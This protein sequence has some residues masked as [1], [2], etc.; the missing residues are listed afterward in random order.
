ML[1]DLIK[2]TAKLAIFA[3]IVI[4]VVLPNVPGIPK[5]G[6]LF[7]FP[8]WQQAVK[9]LIDPVDLTG[10]V[11]KVHQWV[12][13]KMP[14]IKIGSLSVPKPKF[15]PPGANVLDQDKST[16]EKLKLFVDPGGLVPHR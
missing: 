4:Y 3:A 2:F 12:H 1:K 7:H 14:D 8:S 11:E 10:R 9:F 5:P 13:S 6:D 15:T 16:E